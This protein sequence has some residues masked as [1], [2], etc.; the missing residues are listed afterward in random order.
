MQLTIK[1]RYIW[2]L[3]QI[4]PK[5]VKTEWKGVGEC[6][7]FVVRGK[8]R[9]NQGYWLIVVKIQRLE[10]GKRLRDRPFWK[11]K[12]LQEGVR[13]IEKVAHEECRSW[14]AL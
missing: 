3:H 14:R 13:K 7:L 5:V 11:K 8:W 2:L 4:T 12:K 6:M 1:R 9:G 10:E